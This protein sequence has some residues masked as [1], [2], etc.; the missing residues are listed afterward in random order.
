MTA[1]ELGGAPEG[2]WRQIGHQGAVTLLCQPI[3]KQKNKKAHKVR[4]TQDS[5]AGIMGW[6]TGQKFCVIQFS[7]ELTR[8]QTLK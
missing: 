6:S 5:S 8:C 3:R 4:T 2:R 7:P 1:G